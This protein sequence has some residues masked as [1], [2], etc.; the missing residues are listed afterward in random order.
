MSISVLRRLPLDEERIRSL[1]SEILEIPA[2]QGRF[3]DTTSVHVIE[4][5]MTKITG[6]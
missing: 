3:W 6:P 1:Y 5:V 4:E 2:L